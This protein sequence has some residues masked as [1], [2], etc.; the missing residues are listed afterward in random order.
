MRA[1]VGAGGASGAPHPAIDYLSSQ[2]GWDAEK[3]AKAGELLEQN[4]PPLVDAKTLSAIFGISDSLP[5]AIRHDATKYY[6]SWDIPRKSGSRPRRIHS[7]RVVLKVIQRWI[8]DHILRE[9]GVHEAATAFVSGRG[10][11]QNAEPHLEAPAFMVMDIRDFFPSINLEQIT[12]VFEQCGYERMVAA[13]LARLCM[14]DDGLP[15]GAPTSPAI[16]NLV[17]RDVDGELTSLAGRWDAKYT[18]YA[19]DMA[20]SSATYTFSEDDSEQ[21]TSILA[22]AKFEVNAAKT[23]RIGRGFRHEIAGLVTNEKAQ[24]PR[25]KR[26]RWRT[27]F[28]FADKYPEAHADQVDELLGLAGF[29]KQYDPRHG[30]QYLEVAQKVR[31]V[32]ESPQAH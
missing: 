6:R 20:F 18:R 10:I 2:L 9:Q 5:R 17:M 25:W 1:A 24:P 29:V 21:V 27:L 16:S 31:Q 14:L 13:D 28:H 11:F 4:L 30:A 3:T 32:A 12:I 19:D 7:P 8:Y 15:Q 26:R 22:T 23:R